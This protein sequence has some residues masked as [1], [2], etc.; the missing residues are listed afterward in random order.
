MIVPCSEFL[1]RDLDETR[2]PEVY[3][4]NRVVFGK[5]SAPMEAQ[6][7]AQENARR[8]QEEFPKAAETV[9][10]ST[11]MDDSIDSVE[12]DEEGVELYQQ[13]DG[14]WKLAG[15]QARKWISNSPEVVAATP[16]DDRATEL[17][18]TDS[19]DGVVKTLGIS[20]NS[21]DDT[22]AIS[23]PECSSTIPL[24]KRN[25][26][27]RIAM[28]FD[29]L[30]L[31]SPFVVVA[32]MQLQELWS[33]SYDW[34]DV[35]VDEI[36]NRISKWIRHMES[37]ADIRVPRCLREAKKV[38]KKSVVTFVDAS[39]KAYGTVAYLLCEYEDT[40]VSCRLVASKTKVAPLK[41]ISVP[42]LELMAAVLGLRLTQRLV[43]T[44]EVS[45]DIVVFYS[46]SNDVLWWIRG[47]GREFR[48]FVA[49][50]IGEIQMN[51]EPAQWQYVPT[52][53][54]PA[55]LCTRG[56]TPQE[57]SDCSLW[58]NGPQWL[59]DD[60]EKWP[61]MKLDNRPTNLPETKASNKQCEGEQSDVAKTCHYQRPVIE[62]K[63]V[64]DQNNLDWRLDPRRYSSWVQLVRVHARVWR[65]VNNMRKTEKRV[66]RELLPEERRDAE[67]DIIRLAQ[68]EV[69]QDEYKALAEKKPISQK[70][71]L[72]KFNPC[73]G[74]Q[75]MI[76]SDSRLRFA[77]Y[78]PYDARFPIILPRG[79]W[80]TRLIVRYFHELANHS[81]GTNYVLAQ[82]SERY[83]IPA[84]RD[85]I[86]ECES[87]CNEC[88]KWR[89]K[90][91]T[92]VMAPLPP[93]RLRITYRAFDQTGVDYAG[94]INTVQGRGKTRQKRWLCVFTCFSTRA[95]HIEVAWRLD[96][97]GFLN[98]FARFTSRR[99]VP[100]EMTSDNGTNF[101]GAVN[102][103]KELVAGLDKD[104]IQRVGGQGNIKW[105]FNPPAAPHFGG[106]FEA[107]V[108][109]AKKAVYAV[110]GSSDVTDEELITACTGVEGLL[111]SRPLTYQSADPR[112]DVPLT[113]NHFLHGQAGGN[114]APENV[115]TTSFNPRKRW[116]K[117]QELISRVWSRWMKEYL[118]SLR[119]RPKWNQIVKA[120][121]SGDVVLVFD[122][123]I[124]R[125]RWP[126]GRILEMYPG[127]DGHA[128]VAK[129]QCGGKTLVRPIH[130][131][132]PLELNEL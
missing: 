115:D 96:T 102:E 30:G 127:R 104:K 8:H 46:D 51:T 63:E 43:S 118:P 19:Q 29:S 44:L 7:V 107:M 56:T 48:A 73:L 71:T 20:W 72:V 37:L 12:T 99:G 121:K 74:E 5:N 3:E 2:E 94:P 45:M 39:L 34:D 27:K 47:H 84:A 87:Q 1:W 38:V 13:L 106:V 103:L 64:K 15:M 95:I 17:K 89:N 90:T 92:Q 24:T 41:P 75:G 86:K 111:N 65:V 100:K 25:V 119:A 57:L 62:R 11:Y 101:V 10:K 53:H 16:E 22:L 112:D 61:K 50:R 91:A 18:L 70:S 69:F 98:A 54:N 76:R 83:W 93:N 59:L 9:L 129:V 128:R 35:I 66:G 23:S 60:R 113:P 77:E 32:K 131:L 108:K 33:R 116:R 4:F 6:F 67:E 130:K 124:P 123:D 88:K 132:V 26:L 97:D 49:N 14:L 40:T 79:H 82:I 42:R 117:V 58:W 52:D 110:L 78:L 120:L 36:A 126:L 55:D 122:Q 21:K 68:Q 114:F 85:E 80:V 81:A 125:G 109:A 28:L 31:V 105:K